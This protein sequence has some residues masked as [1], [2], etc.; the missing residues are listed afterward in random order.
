MEHEKLV[1]LVVSAMFA[2][3]C[4]VATMVIQIRTVGTSGY[5]NI[6]DT[7]VLL[8]AWLIGGVYGAAAAG[9]GSAMADLLAS[10][11]TFVPG[12]FVIKFFM[13]VAAYFVFKAL[14]K[15]KVFP[16]AAYII[17]AVIAECIMVG[18]YFLYESV[19]L[20]YGMGAVPSIG[21]NAIQGGTCLVLGVIAVEILEVSG[22]MKK[23]RNELG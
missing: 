22:A 17:S 19:I 11:V 10:Y 6:G 9:I 23:V 12:T 8:C 21:S 18:G 4:C 15:A 1:K 5:V 3:I 13:A 7:I 2:A 16:L 14:K 20:G